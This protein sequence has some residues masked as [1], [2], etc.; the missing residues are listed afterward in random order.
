LP[1]TGVCSCGGNLNASEEIIGR[2]KKFSTFGPKM[3]DIGTF[4]GQFSTVFGIVAQSF[5]FASLC[6][7]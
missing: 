3:V 1:E 4:I 2:E 6:L 7:D 5:D